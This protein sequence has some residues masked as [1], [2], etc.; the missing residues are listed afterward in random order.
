MSAIV[1]WSRATAKYNKAHLG[2]TFQQRGKNRRATQRIC[3]LWVLFPLKRYDN[4]NN[5]ESVKTPIQIG[6]TENFLTLFCVFC[7]TETRPT[8]NEDKDHWIIIVVTSIIWFMNCLFDR[9]NDTHFVAH[10]VLC[11]LFRGIADIF[12]IFNFEGWQ[13]YYVWDTEIGIH[14]L[15]N[16]Q[17]IIDFEWF[18]IFVYK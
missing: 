1:C 15:S 5:N 7:F 8:V 16:T 9:I 3:Q 14:T 2:F 6:I 10:S 18:S 11:L 17:H 13:K 4:N 12:A